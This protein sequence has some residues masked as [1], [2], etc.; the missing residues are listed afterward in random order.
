M[1]PN[2]SRRQPSLARRQPA[3]RL[4][5]KA[6]HEQLTDVAMPLVAEQGAN[7]S[8]DE[9]AA[10]ASVTRNLLYHYF[11][12]GRQDILVAVAERA[13]HELTDDW[14]I[15]E[16]IPVQER[17]AL[18][19]SRFVAHAMAPTDAWQV[20]RFARSALNPELDAIV[21]D[22]EEV[23]VES[24]SLN[25]LGTATPP[26]LV[27]LAIKGLIVFIETLLD[28]ARKHDVPPEKVLPI[29]AQTLPTTLQ[30]AL[31]ADAADT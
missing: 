22:F 5:R 1:P 19:F 31:A 29:V 16:E 23:I 17:L 24:V 20:H 11:P 25:N 4:A 26:Q 10:E 9:L 15:A 8:L 3:R 13:G 21:D 14:V 18:N 12:R 28:E 2:P 30:A 27:R 7:F 6:R